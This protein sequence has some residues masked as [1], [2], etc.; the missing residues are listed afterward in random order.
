MNY[1]RTIT[2]S[3]FVHGSTLT[4]GLISAKPY[5][6]K[7]DFGSLAPSKFMSLSVMYKRVP[8]LIH[9]RFISKCF[10]FS[11]IWANMFKQMSKNATM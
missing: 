4:R 1:E 9:R 2:S 11:Q 5:R 6:K 10:I 8:P 7:M 3:L